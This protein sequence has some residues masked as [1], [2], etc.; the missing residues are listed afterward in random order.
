ML[1]VFEERDDSAQPLIA[2]DI[3]DALGCGGFRSAICLQW[4]PTHEDDSLFDLPTFSGEDPTDVSANV[5]DH[6]A[7]AIADE[8]DRDDNHARAVFDGIQ[9]GALVYYPLYTTGYVLAELVT[10][11]I[12]RTDRTIVETARADSGIGSRSSTQLLP[13]S[14]APIRS[15]DATPIRI[16]HLSTT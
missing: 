2:T 6:V 13:I 10:L 7:A 4:G 14:L 12:V 1:D 15:F 11:A 16:I 8:N 3:A 5:D 9:T